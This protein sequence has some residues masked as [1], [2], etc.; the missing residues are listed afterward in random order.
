M[1]TA[2]ADIGVWDMALIAAIAFFMSVVAGLSGYGIGLVLPA[3]IAPVIGVVAVIPVMSVAM[4]FAN[5]SRMW[6]YRQSLSRRT[7]ALLMATSLPAAAAG[8]LLYVRLPA[9]AI[10]IALGA[11]FIASV[12]LRRLM[13]YWKMHIG[14]RGL[15]AI[16]AGYGFLAGGMTGTGLLLVAGLLAAGVHG[17]ALIATDSAI[18]VAINLLKIAVFGNSALLTPELAVAGTLI[19]LC[20]V[21]GAFIARRIMDHLPVHVHVWIMEVLV[22]GGGTSFL[23]RAL[24]G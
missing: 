14:R 13:G 17:A 6:A 8:A 3:F 11:F 12:P 4:T 1:E 20:T 9:H 18:S 5:A 23:W 16:G 10:A 24:A 7:V 21:P 2:L 22:L 15:A 19:G